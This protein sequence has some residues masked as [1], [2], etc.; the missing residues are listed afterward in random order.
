VATRLHPPINAI[1]C[2][3]LKKEVQATLNH[4][5]Y[6][7]QATMILREWTKQ[8]RPR[9]GPQLV[10]NTLIELED[11][12]GNMFLH[13]P[14]GDDQIHYV[15]SAELLAN[16]PIKKRLRP[17]GRPKTSTKQKGFDNPH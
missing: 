9:A 1:A 5:K 2:E 6:H 8:G 13:G 14:T 11:K 17:V 3:L 7:E 16:R 15:L 10:G 12:A 4:D